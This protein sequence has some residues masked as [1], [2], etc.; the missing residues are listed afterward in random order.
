[1]KLYIYIAIIVSLAHIQF[2][3]AKTKAPAVDKETY[4]TDFLNCTAQTS[5]RSYTYSFYEERFMANHQSTGSGNL[6]SHE[7]N[8]LI[9]LSLI[10]V[11]K[12]ETTIKINFLGKAYKGLSISIDSQEPVSIKLPRTDSTP[13]LEL[14]CFI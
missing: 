1:M 11:E 8:G 2:A 9:L 10:S 14:D 13:P 12:S 3:A 5:N 4:I 6:S 7:R